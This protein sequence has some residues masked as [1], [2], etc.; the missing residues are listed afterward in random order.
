[1]SY[2][3]VFVITLLV[4]IAWTKYLLRAAE[5]RAHPASMWS[6]VIVG[7]G[8]LNVLVYTQNPWALIPAAAG[9]YIGT[10]WTIKREKRN[11]VPVGS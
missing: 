2:V 3:A 1:M 10:W 5:K 8:G 7:L 6:A 4:D 11:E 9:A